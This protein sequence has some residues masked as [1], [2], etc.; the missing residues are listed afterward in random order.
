MGFKVRVYSGEQTSDFSLEGRD[1]FSVGGKL[2][3]SDSAV[4][5]DDLTFKSDALVKGFLKLYLT[6]GKWYVSCV[7]K[8][9]VSSD[10]EI[11]GGDF[12]TID[13][14]NQFAI[15]I[16]EEDLEKAGRIELNGRDRINIGRSM[17]G[18]IR[19][20]GKNLKLPGKDVSRSHA[21]IYM[22]D[23]KYA[24]A[25]DNSA[26][27]VY[28]NGDVIS[29]GVFLEDGDKIG[30]AHH[31]LQY[32][33]GT[34]LINDVSERVREER[35]G[36]YPFWYKPAPRLRR[37]L[38]K[39][40][41]EIDAPPQK[42]SKPDESIAQRLAMPIVSI[43]ALCVL[44]YITVSSTITMLIFTLPMSVVTIVFTIVNSVKNKKKYRLA[45]EERKEKY[46]E[47]LDIME[48]KIKKTAGLQKEALNAE[49]PEFED[50]YRSVW[51]G[52]GR[53]WDRTAADDDFMKVR[54]GVGDGDAS[55][56]VRGPKE[57]FSLEEDDLLKRVYRIE[58]KSKK[59]A[60]I[61]VIADIFEDRLIGILGNRDRAIEMVLESGGISHPGLF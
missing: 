55:Y 54:I 25:D 12:F 14:V 15:S 44:A 32:K 42:P 29:G 60:Q 11:R 40:V 26:N 50:I 21:Y 9:I 2:D 19:F 10:R 53:L 1:Y 39:D 56:E 22:Y 13:N 59:V 52:D 36:K 47:Y 30:I 43:I 4:V 51:E 58:R 24:I 45:V 31:T 28:L 18:G 35:M 38:P 48:D 8:R 23:G 3:N 6:N 17:E 33:N 20:D 46:T 57:G 49:Y 41:I 34:I 61:P 7:D 37:E 27:H 5:R 16:I